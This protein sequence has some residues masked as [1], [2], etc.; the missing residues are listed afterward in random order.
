MTQTNPGTWEA[1]E[2]DVL[3]EDSV[4]NLSELIV[5][6]DDINTFDWVIESLMDICSHSFEQA[7]QLSLLVHFKGK[8]IVKTA[9]FSVLR[10]M[11]DAL[12][13]RGLS[14]VIETIKV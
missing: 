2:E 6:N 13:E 8:A 14:A 5:Y 4:G 9:S 1:I 10:P 3:V 12:C 7:E 11:K